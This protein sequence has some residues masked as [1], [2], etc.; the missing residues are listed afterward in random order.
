MQATEAMPIF[1]LNKS[2]TSLNKSK[3]V[4]VIFN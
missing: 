3:E 1:L 2:L 4:L